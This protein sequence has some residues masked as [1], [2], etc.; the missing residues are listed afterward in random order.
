MKRIIQLGAA[1]YIDGKGYPQGLTGQQIPLWARMTAVADT[2]AAL[3]SERPYQS[4][5]PLDRALQI[6][7]NVRG[8]QLCPECVDIFLEWITST[9]AKQL[10][11]VKG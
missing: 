5:V 3:I 10:K 9:H 6:I 4:V 2:Y 8:T 7:K 1:G 11:A